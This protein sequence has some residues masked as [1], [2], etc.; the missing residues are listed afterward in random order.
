MPRPS[1]M[2]KLLDNTAGRVQRGS[3]PGA[4]GGKNG[5]TAG[6]PLA[7]VSATLPSASGVNSPFANCCAGALASPG[8]VTL[9]GA[10]PEDTSY[11]N[12]LPFV[13]D[14]VQTS[15]WLSAEV[16]AAGRI[17]VLLPR[18]EKLGS[19]TT[20]VIALSPVSE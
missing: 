20:P 5:E 10:F 6:P 11:V 17:A 3:S 2:T 15:D 7:G 1:L 8:K 18:G 4:R 13:F 12:T 16:T 9:R 14:S 19:S